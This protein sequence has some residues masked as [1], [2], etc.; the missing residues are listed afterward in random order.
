MASSR[1]GRGVSGPRF[2]YAPRLAPLTSKQ[3]NEVEVD[4]PERTVKPLPRSHRIALSLAAL[5]SLLLTTIASSAG[6]ALPQPIKP[7]PEST[8]AVTVI[9]LP[10]AHP[11]SAAAAS[12]IVEHIPVDVIGLRHE[13]PNIEGEYFFDD[14]RSV[15]E[16]LEDFRSDFGT[17]P[18]ITSLIAQTSSE[19]QAS[20]YS[21]QERELEELVVNLTR[22]LPAFEASPPTPNLTEVETALA[23]EA[24]QRAS[25]ASVPTWFPHYYEMYALGVTSTSANLASYMIWNGGTNSPTQIPT[26]WGFEVD[27]VQYNDALFGTRPLCAPGVRDAFWAARDQ[28]PSAVSSWAVYSLTGDLTNSPFIGAY[29]DWVDDSDPCGQQNLSVGIGYPRNLPA[30][31]DGSVVLQTVIHTWRG[32]ETSSPMSVNVQVV[33]NDCNDIGSEPNSNC[34]D[35]NVWR[36]FPLGSKG[37]VVSGSSNGYSF[38]GCYYTYWDERA[39]QM[40]CP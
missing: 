10:T 18:E 33:S 27:M 40:S 9:R 5:A 12:S 31:A 36:N 37:F 13:Q 6:A 17:D 34:M 26:D 7:E 20:V 14:R 15:P 1:M 39:Q 22:E 28:G 16:F 2:P 4:N 23:R 11:I 19:E 30:N 3:T 21:G 29:L 32:T 24:E 35:L 38:P 25:I 8:S